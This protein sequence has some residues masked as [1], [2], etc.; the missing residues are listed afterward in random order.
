VEEEETRGGGGV[1]G[2]GKRAKLGHS[3]HLTDKRAVAPAGDSTA[4][5]L[6]IAVGPPV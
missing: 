3:G 2:E 1:A 5:A 4:S 6:A